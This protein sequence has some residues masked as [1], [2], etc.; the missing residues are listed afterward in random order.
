MAKIPPWLIVMVAAV[1]VR[2]G[3]QGLSAQDNTLWK[4][5]TGSRFPSSG[6][7]KTGR[8]SLSARPTRRWL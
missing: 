5:R 8:L 1:V 4:C 7:T 3:R 6:G 2:V